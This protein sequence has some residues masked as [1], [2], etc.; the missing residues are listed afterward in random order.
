VHLLRSIPLCQT[1]PRAL[2]RGTKASVLTS[3]TFGRFITHSLN[4]NSLPNQCTAL[5][6]NLPH[7]RIFLKHN[8]T[9]LFGSPFPPMHSLSLSFHMPLT[10]LLSLALRSI[11][12]L[13]LPLTVYSDT[14]PRLGTMALRAS[15]WRWCRSSDPS[16][17]RRL[18]GSSAA[19]M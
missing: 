11:H 13:I 18:A 9:L 14:P 6:L 5:L 17:G 19:A 1:V 15:V 12:T 3:R 2:R 8:G 10:C 16:S 7:R 4:S